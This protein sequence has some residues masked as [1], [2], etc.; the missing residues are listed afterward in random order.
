MVYCLIKL[1]AIIIFIIIII[2]IIITFLVPSASTLHNDISNGA[3]TK[4]IYVN[5]QC[6]AFL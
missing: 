2:I 6:T 1:L 4:H 5:M 3:N